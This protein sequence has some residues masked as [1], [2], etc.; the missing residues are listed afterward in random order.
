MCCAASTANFVLCEIKLQYLD[1]YK[2]IKI[3]TTQNHYTLLLCQLF[4]FV[5]YIYP[6]QNVR[7]AKIRCA[8][9]DY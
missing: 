9:I 2:T 1:D 8:L 3:I 5:F 4:V 6:K 7:L